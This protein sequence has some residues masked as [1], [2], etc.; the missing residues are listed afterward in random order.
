MSY[1]LSYFFML[2]HLL[3]Y[4]LIQKDKIKL[5]LIH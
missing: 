3:A 1:K 5:H 2:F 4:N